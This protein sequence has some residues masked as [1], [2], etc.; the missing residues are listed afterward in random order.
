MPATTIAY[1]RHDDDDWTDITEP[2]TEACSSMGLGQ[3]V[4]GEDYSPFEAMSAIELM[5]PK[6]DVGLQTPANLEKVIDTIGDLSDAD[7]K[8]V[9]DGML[10]MM[11][12]YFNGNTTLQTV[13]SCLLC[14]HLD[15]VRHAGLKYFLNL[16]LRCSGLA[17]EIML[18][19]DVIADEDAPLAL[20]GADLEPK[21]LPVVTDCLGGRIALLEE[22]EEMLECVKNSKNEGCKKTVVDEVL[23]ALQRAGH[24]G[25][26][27]DEEERR[28]QLDRLFD[29]SINNNDMPPGEDRTCAGLLEEGLELLD[30][31]RTA[32]PSTFVES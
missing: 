30:G 12:L 20:L 29:A 15:A 16:A 22:L 32:P 1:T 23:D 7:A 8:Y 11:Y 21:K 13:W 18:E 2:I 6:M 31:V 5:Q 24:D 26:L 3:L 19:S 27:V 14:H 17:R 28:K 9:A 4:H 25:V 10:A